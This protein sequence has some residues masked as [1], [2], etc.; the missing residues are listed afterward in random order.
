M[1]EGNQLCYGRNLHER[2]ITAMTFFN[3]LKYLVTGA[4]DGTSKYWIENCSG[5]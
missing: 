2:E 3:P 4:L 1:Y 5:V